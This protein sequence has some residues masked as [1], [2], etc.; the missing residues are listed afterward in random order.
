MNETQ[1]V[2]KYFWTSFFIIKEIDL[3]KAFDVASLGFCFVW[4]RMAILGLHGNTDQ[5]VSSKQGI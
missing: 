1:A 5:G 3:T 2:S 4:S